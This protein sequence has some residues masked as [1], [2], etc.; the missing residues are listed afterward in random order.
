[1][2][3]YEDYICLKLFVL[4]I[5]LITR[6]QCVY[7]CVCVC[8]CVCSVTLRRVREIIL[9]ME[10]QISVTYSECVSVALGI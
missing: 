1:M 9:S 10:K 5:T 3:V 2:F 4:T 8:V 7:V 6:E